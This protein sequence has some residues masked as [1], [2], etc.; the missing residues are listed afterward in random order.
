MVR[1]WAA[2]G[3]A[4]FLT[5]CAG[6]YRLTI[7][8]AVTAP[9]KPAPVVVRLERQEFGPLYLPVDDAVMRMWVDDEPLRAAYT[10]RNGYASAAVPCPPQPGR[11]RLTVAHQDREGGQVGK[12]ALAYVVRPEARTLVVEWESID[13]TDRAHQ[14]APALK[15]LAAAGVQIVYA[16]EDFEEPVAAH[17][18]LAQNSLPDGP[19]VYW[20][21]GRQVTGTVVTLRA[22]LT[23]PV[24]AA[25]AEDDFLRA[26]QTLSITPACVGAQRQRFTCYESWD[27]LA[28]GVLSAGSPEPPH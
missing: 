14:A 19:L 17:A 3:M 21:E 10:R 9:D 1:F 4:A 16:A 13:K 7:P 24:I 22:L 20:A 28:D 11:H 8:D 25:G 18:F 23:G 2:C 5:G 6:S 27:A 26:L 12:K 15:R